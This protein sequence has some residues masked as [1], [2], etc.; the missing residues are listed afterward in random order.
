MCSDIYAEGSRNRVV[1]VG[2]EL[3]DSKG[4]NGVVWD[5]GAEDK[6]ENTDGGTDGD[7]ED[8][9]C[10]KYAAKSTAAAASFSTFVRWGWYRVA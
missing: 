3:G 6:E 1:G 5:F 10:T 9:E 4:V 8:E 2:G 7:D